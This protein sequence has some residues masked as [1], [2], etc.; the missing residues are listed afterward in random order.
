MSWHLNRREGGAAMKQLSLNPI[1]DWNPWLL[2]TPK[3]GQRFQLI[4]NP[5]RDWNPI[6]WDVAD[7]LL[8]RSN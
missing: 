3:I 7:Y 4:L 6:H 2:S 1:R 5:I 8:K